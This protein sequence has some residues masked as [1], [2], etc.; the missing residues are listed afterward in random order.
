MF[1]K[2]FHKAGDAEQAKHVKLSPYK[3]LAQSVEIQKQK[4]DVDYVTI[5][6]S[7]MDAAQKISIISFF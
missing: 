5:D 6:E 7:S 2:S 3:L 4:S 1:Q